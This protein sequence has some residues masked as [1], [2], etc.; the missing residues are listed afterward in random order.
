[1]ADAGV[2]ILPY[3]EFLANLKKRQDGAALGGV[4]DAN[5][6]PKMEVIMISLFLFS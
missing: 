6:Q 2:T 5:G 1:M 4:T 3:A